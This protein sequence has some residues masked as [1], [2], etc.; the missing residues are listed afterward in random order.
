M[1]EAT[2]V[3]S[4]TSWLKQKLKKDFNFEESHPE[5]LLTHSKTYASTVHTDGN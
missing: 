2:T 4:G 5:I 1:P 3:I